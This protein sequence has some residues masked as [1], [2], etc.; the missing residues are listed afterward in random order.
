MLFFYLLYAPRVGGPHGNKFNRESTAPSRRHNAARCVVAGVVA[1]HRSARS[2]RTLCD[3]ACLR[4][5]ILRMGGVHFSVLPAPHLPPSSLVA[6]FSSAAD[7]GV[8]FGIPRHLLLLPQ[9][10]LSSFL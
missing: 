10:V 9:G 4:R 8:P 2:I 3:C 6:V 5:D 7:P 1:R